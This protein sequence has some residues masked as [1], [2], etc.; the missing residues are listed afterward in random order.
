[1]KLPRRV[2]PALVL[3]TFAALALATG[4]PILR[5]LRLWWRGLPGWLFWPLWAVP[6]LAFS[7]GGRLP[8]GAFKSLARHLGEGWFGLCLYPLL[9]TFAADAVWLIAR[10]CGRALPLR[11]T[12][13]A[14]L[15]LCALA[16]LYGMPHALR[17]RVTRYRVR[18][19]RPCPPLRLVLL[20][21][22]H[23]GFFTPRRLLRRL[24]ALSNDL[25]P[26]AVLI[27]GDLFDEEYR[28]LRHPE[29]AAAALASM[30]SPLGTFACEGN[31]DLFCP[32]PE[33]AAFFDAA[34][35]RLLRDESVD[36]GAFVLFG[37]R[38]RRGKAR[39]TPPELLAQADGRK[40]I[41]VLDHNPNGYETVLDAGADLVLCGHTHGGQTFP[42]NLLG[43]L[44]P[45]HC[46]GEARRGGGT[47]I[48]TSGAGIWGLPM[49]I[50]VPTELVCIDLE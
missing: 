5:W 38:D 46:Y 45:W 22:L 49:R 11:E 14:V 23:M 8:R 12:G 42:G 32:G 44:L 3:C 26:D 20:S 36:L 4:I 34:H 50:G 1:M 39:L 48:V 21:D 2:F 35:I 15:A 10:L 37:R 33:K 30:R 43:R 25:A 47:C 19:S 17:P 18:L 13:W 41:L 6:P 7:L 9:L 16:F 31:H 27:A 40:P 28:V 29:E 24:A